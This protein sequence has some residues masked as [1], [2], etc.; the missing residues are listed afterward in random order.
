MPYTRPRPFSAP[1]WRWIAIGLAL[2]TLMVARYPAIAT[3]KNPEAI[4]AIMQTATVHRADLSG[5]ILV[6]GRISSIQSTEIRCTLERLSV[7][8]QRGSP[9]GGASTILSL[10]PEGT[11]VQKGELLCEMDA[12]AYAELVDNQQIAVEQARTN[13]LQ[14]ALALDVARIALEA[15]REGEKVQV[16]SAYMGQIA[17]AQADLTRQN[18]RIE[19]LKRMVEKGY[20]SLA[21]LQSEQ[22]AHERL[23]ISVRKSEL[24]LVNYRRFTAPRELLILQSQVIGAQATLGFQDLR[25]NREQERLTHYKTMLDRCTI[26]APHGG[27]VVY[28][29]RSGRSPVVYEGAPV[30]ERMP[31]F[32][33]P[34]QSKLE[35]EVLLHETIFDRVRPGMAVGIRLEAL[36]ELKLTGVLSSVAPVPVS[37][38]NPESGNDATYFV[39]HVE[40]SSVPSKLRP[41]MTTQVTIST[42]LRPGVLAVPTM[43]V[44]V[45]DEHEVCYVDHEKSVE[46]RAV[47]VTQASRDMLEV[48][49][50]L[51][52]GE[53]VFL[54]PALL[55][56]RAAP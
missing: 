41:G 35:V 13:R 19:W 4:S 55:A 46:R 42:G 11:N 9:G 24:A 8:G 5:E 36:P 10:V 23:K 28:A 12:S 26:R 17:L 48:I 51:S 21:Q 38:K 49:D 15:Y 40:L 37:D 16:E 31:L 32:T 25:L 29:N 7:A 45:E 14:A 27:Y 44:A 6:S 30:R 43:A 52:E 20:V 2:T 54:D 50:G 39:G 22:I 34:D 3:L 53:V 18:D 33:L 56:S 47:K 1:R